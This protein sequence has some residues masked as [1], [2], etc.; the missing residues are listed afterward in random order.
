MNFFINHEILKSLLKKFSSICLIYYMLKLMT[1]SLFQRVIM[2]SD[3]EQPQ[4]LLKIS[5]RTL[6]MV[7]GSFIS[8]HCPRGNYGSLE[9]TV[10]LRSI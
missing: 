2:T 9:K 5:G 10:I 6:K 7:N 3:P 1:Y 4:M 8:N